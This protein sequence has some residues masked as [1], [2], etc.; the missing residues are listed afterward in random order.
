MGSRHSTTRARHPRRWVPLLLLGLAVLGIGAAAT[1]ALAA[2]RGQL[3]N[4][5]VSTPAGPRGART[6]SRTGRTATADPTA[7]PAATADPAAPAATAYP[8]TPADPAHSVVGDPAATSRAEGAT[9]DGRKQHVAPPVTPNAPNPNCTLTVPP[10]PLT[11]AG[12]ATPYQLRGS[13]GGGD[14]HEANAAQS[15][16]VEA[17]V[18]DPATGALSVYHP[19]VVDAGTRPAAPPVPVTLPARAVVGV[20][21]GFQG[22]TLTLA[23]APADRQTCVNGLPGSPFGQF[24]DCNGADFFAAANT[25][26]TAGALKVPP[27]GTGRDGLPCPTT[28]DFGVVD[29]DQSDNLV[30]RYVATRDGRIGQDTPANAA[31]GGT[32]LTNASDNGLLD[33]ALD[34]ALGCTPFTAPD[35]TAGAAPSPSLALNELQAAADQRAPVATVPLNDPMS[36]V[37]DRTAPAKADQYRA[38]VDMTPTGAADPGDGAAYCRNLAAV[39]PARLAADRAFTRA[40]PSPDP[41]AATTLFGFLTQRLTASWQNLGCQDLVHAGPPRVDG[42]TR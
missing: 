29:Q 42:G 18:L 6:P 15:A 34:P 28:R 24:A 1:P 27:L 22:V 19:L 9:R 4:G 17:T 32:V 5:V 14:C 12:L 25:A 21:F 36:K 37:G 31:L 41:A 3:G 35:L 39:A 20:W 23:T 26:I 30:T 8:N 2:G 38:G 13:G 10:A 33:T 11:A 40:A 7:T 16:F